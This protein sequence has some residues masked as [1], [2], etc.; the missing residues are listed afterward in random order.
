MAVDKPG[1]RRDAAHGNLNT[2]SIRPWGPLCGPDLGDNIHN[3]IGLHG[4]PYVTVNDAGQYTVREETAFHVIITEQALKPAT[5]PADSVTYPKEQGVDLDPGNPVT[6][7]KR[8]LRTPSATGADGTRGGVV[9][10]EVVATQG[11][12]A[13]AKEQH[14]ERNCEIWRFS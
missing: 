10:T 1:G 3:R 7:L 12:T 6:L 8:V 4:G 9:R 11:A 2:R 13:G 5:P 14:S